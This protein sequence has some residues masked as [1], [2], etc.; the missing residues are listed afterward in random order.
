MLAAIDR[1]WMDV[2][3]AERLA[4]LRVI[5]GGYALVYLAIRTPHLMSYA[6]YDPALF[7]PVGLATLAPA[8][9]IPIV[10][11][12]LVVAT[13]LLAVPFVL[14]FRHRVLAPVFAGLLLWVLTY[15]NSW[16]KI[17]HTD[18]LLVLHVGVLA[19]AP[20]AD[21]I[22]IDARR[23]GAAV[24][25]DRRYGWPIR[26]MC[27]LCVVVYLLAGIAKVEN[28]GLAFVAGDTLR[29]YVAFDNVR[30]LELGS[31]HSPLGA[32]LLGWSGA[33]GALAGLSFVLELGAPLA[34]ANRRVGAVWVALVWGFHVGVLLLMAIGFAY[35]LTGVAFAS[36]FRVEKVLEIRAL[37]RFRAASSA[38]GVTNAG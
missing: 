13:A 3:P 20:A 15:S 28:S 14:G 35:Q 4:M 21:A 11:Q 6:H 10:V 34:M 16:G 26:L 30:K 33:F 37:R 31:I 12:A 17:L 22:S 32:A 1:Y 8:P 36:F 27:A 29:N 7:Q 9:L 38:G 24:A 18:N 5:V 19:L 2:V 23:E 25:P